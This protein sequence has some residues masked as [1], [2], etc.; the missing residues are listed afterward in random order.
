MA[1]SADCKVLGLT[2]PETH[3]KSE[4]IESKRN[5]INDFIMGFDE[6]KL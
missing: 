6:E 1:L 4:A 5:T 2:I 3:A